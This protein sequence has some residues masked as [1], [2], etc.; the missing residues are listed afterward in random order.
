MSSAITKLRERAD[1]LVK[2]GKLTKAIPYYEKLEELEPSKPRWPQMR[3]RI[4]ERMGETRQ[5][6]EAYT[7]AANHFAQEGFLLKAVAVCK[8]I[9]ALDPKHTE[10]QET[11][12]DLYARKDSAVSGVKRVPP[13]DAR[14]STQPRRAIAPGAPLETVHLREAFPEVASS[15][16]VSEQV[17]EIPLR[18][19]GDKTRI[20]LTESTETTEEILRFLPPTP[21]LTSLNRHAL[22]MMIER[23]EVL[24]FKPWQ[25]V[26]REDDEDDSLYIVID[27]QAVVLKEGA[28]RQELERLEDG[29]VFGE[30]ALL[31]ETR[32]P[33][34]VQ[35]LEPLTLLRVS[36]AVMGELISAE[37]SVLKVLLGFFRERLLGTWL[38]TTP[39]LSAFSMSARLQLAEHFSLV[40]VERGHILEQQGRPTDSMY[41]VLAGELEV[42]RS[43]EGE[44]KR[45]SKLRRG[46]LA[47]VLPLLT[48]EPSVF[49]LRAAQRTWLLRL[50]FAEFGQLQA[51]YA[52]V[53]IHLKKLAAERRNVLATMSYLDVDEDTVP[54][55]L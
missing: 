21:L 23:A 38:K 50:G 8:I 19:A 51:Q 28:Q 39:L 17:L 36:R 10:T 15:S 5:A 11:L 47:G 31:S 27:G 48:G 44:Q 18:R 30:V 13:S 1:T 45:V 46:G 12:A 41:A 4:L 52:E 16:D 6:I 55:L 34:A 32:R 42:W 2:R 20:A 22:R 43:S 7:L 25:Y 53:R 26:F 35:A 24:E 29:D 37:R 54:I 49:T 33:T 9:L 3:A 14:R 40:Q